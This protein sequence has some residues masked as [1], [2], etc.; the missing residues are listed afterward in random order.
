[1]TT[2]PKYP[3]VP[4][5]HSDHPN[6]LRSIIRIIRNM[7]QGKTNNTD[8]VTLTANSATTTVTLAAGRLSNDTVIVFMPTTANAA[9][10]F[11]AGSLYV[12]AKNVDSNTFTITHA[13]N[14]QNDRTFSYALIG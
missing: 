11:G 3:D 4:E 2:T 12:S 1:M 9:T 6:L 5:Y 10:E 8:T 13:N 7:M 14:A